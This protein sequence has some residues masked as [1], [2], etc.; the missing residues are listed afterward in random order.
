LDEDR[1]V[2]AKEIFE[3]YLTQGS[4]HY[5]D[6]IEEEVKLDCKKNLSLSSKDLFSKPSK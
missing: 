1:K 6:V 3:T 4:D 5:V 2:S